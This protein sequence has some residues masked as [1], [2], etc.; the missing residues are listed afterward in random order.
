MASGINQSLFIRAL[1]KQP[2]ER[3]PVW[4]MRQ[5]GRYQ[6]SYRALR[7][8]HSLIEIVKT[9]ELA[10]KVTLNAM[11]EFGFDAAIIFSD[12]LIVL[13]AMGLD[14]EFVKG[15]G[16]RLS[17]LV[18]EADFANLRVPSTSAAFAYTLD[19]MRLVA[20]ELDPR[21][22][23]VIGFAGA[24]FTLACYAIEGGGS[25]D[26]SS[27]KKLAYSR[28]DLFDKLCSHI[29]DVSGS[30]LLAQAQAGASA[31]QIF[32]SWAGVLSPHDFARYALPYIK[33]LVGIAKQ[34]GL[35]VIYF[36]TGTTSYLPLLLET[37]ADALS[38]DWRIDIGDAFTSCALQGNL[39]PVKLL[40][41]WSELS[42]D[43]RRILET[44]KR[45][46]QTGYVFNLG[47]GI[48]QHTPEDNVKRVVELV[49]G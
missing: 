34:S 33:K 18:H 19:A 26:F 27:A 12:I 20:A 25:R 4:M 31:L 46:A 48:L 6:A 2:I 13:E 41:T 44:A 15:E 5:A 42:A 8:K 3:F 14:L 43:C 22:L 16:P 29:A 7:E 49:K 32:D 23:P 30:F 37:G 28:P 45:K 10:A 11:D 40:G 9:P 39:D 36:S 1:Q 47:H 21:G 38:V 17:P 24:P 35:P